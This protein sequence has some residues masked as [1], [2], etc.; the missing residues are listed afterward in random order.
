[1]QTKT[2]LLAKIT[3]NYFEFNNRKYF[4]ENAHNMQLGTF[5]EK[6]DPIGSRAYVDVESKV[7]AEHIASRMKYVTTAELD[8]TQVSSGNVGLNGHMPLFGLD[9]KMAVS[10]SYEKG[11]AAKVKLMDFE[12]DEGPLK[13]MLNKDANAARNFLAKEGNDGRICSGIWVWV[14]G[15]VAETVATATSISVSVDDGTKGLSV[16][17]TGGKRGTYTMTITSGTTYAYKLHKVKDWTDRHKT[18]IDNL[19][20]DWKGIG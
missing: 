7:S 14:D 13:T 1:M 8:W 9:G 16:T 2:V 5:G 4:R 18:Q 10:T 20:A 19:E 11:K 17:A 12:I 3:D 15:G 6:K